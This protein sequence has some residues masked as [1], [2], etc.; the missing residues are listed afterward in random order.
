[1]KDIENKI[2]VYSNNVTK[3]TEEHNTKKEVKKNL[4]LF[5]KLRSGK[6][7]PVSIELNENPSVFKTQDSKNIDKSSNLSHEHVSY[8][9]NQVE[10]QIENP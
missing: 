10:N 1:M 9:T 6:N 3:G 8:E 5:S 2:K 7:L 4:G